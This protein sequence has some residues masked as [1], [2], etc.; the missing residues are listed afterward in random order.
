MAGR[1]GWFFRENLVQEDNILDHWRSFTSDKNMASQ[2]FGRSRQGDFYYI[3][4]INNCLMRLSS[5]NEALCF[6]RGLYFTG[7]YLNNFRFYG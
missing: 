3:S 4:I 5:N 7:L 2:I 6:Y 1:Q